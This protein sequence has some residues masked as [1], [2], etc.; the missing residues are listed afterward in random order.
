MYPLNRATSS[1]VI[2]VTRNPNA[3]R[4]ADGSYKKTVDEKVLP[5]STVMRITATD[6]DKVLSM[7]SSVSQTHSVS[8]SL[9]YGIIFYSVSKSLDYGITFYSVSKSLDYSSTF[10][11]WMHSKGYG[12]NLFYRDGCGFGEFV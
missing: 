12:V 8:N 3:P 11:F 4:F 2:S 9:D 1:V 5:G 7:W 6:Q 10:S